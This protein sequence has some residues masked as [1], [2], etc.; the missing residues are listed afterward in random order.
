M[1]RLHV[2]LILWSE[3]WRHE[4][5]KFEFKRLKVSIVSIFCTECRILRIRYKCFVVLALACWPACHGEYFRVHL[6]LKDVEEWDMRRGGVRSNGRLEHHMPHQVD[7]WSMLLLL[8]VEGGV[9]VWS[10]SDNFS[11]DLNK[12]GFSFQRNQ[13]S[14]WLQRTSWE[15]SAGG[16]FKLI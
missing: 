14:T 5:D 16:F 2:Q 1:L 7:G 10:M 12:G 6:R 9:W 15:N 4:S 3:H 13:I 11:K 8:L